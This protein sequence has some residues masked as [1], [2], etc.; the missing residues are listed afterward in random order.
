[1]PL[2]SFWRQMPISP[3]TVSY[4]APVLLM[5]RPGRFQSGTTYMLTRLPLV[6]LVTGGQEHGCTGVVDAWE[7]LQVQSVAC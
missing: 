4:T 1:M 3:Q 7:L 6:L 5:T 2:V